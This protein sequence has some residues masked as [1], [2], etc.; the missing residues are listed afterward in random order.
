NVYWS[1][2]QELSKALRIASKVPGTSFTDNTPWSH[3]DGASGKAVPASN[4]LYNSLNSYYT[5]ALRDFFAYYAPTTATVGGIQGAGNTF[6]L[7]DQ[8]T[9]TKW[10]GTTQTGL[11]IGSYPG[12]TALVLTGSQGTWGRQF[13]G[14][15]I[16]VVMP[17]FSSNTSDP[18]L[19]ALPPFPSNLTSSAGE[20]GTAMVIAG[21]GVFGA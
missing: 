11:T 20:S 5:H 8:A 3:T 15:T 13:S 7:D 16:W 9:M 21:D 4:Y 19:G 14:K 10:T 12:Y 2:G 17:L 18:S 1:Q 6:H